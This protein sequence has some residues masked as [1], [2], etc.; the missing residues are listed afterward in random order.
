MGADDHVSVFVAFDQRQ[1][2]FFLARRRSDRQ[3]HAERFEPAPEHSVMLFRQN[4]R[5]RHERRL[6]ARLDH[7]QD[8]RDRNHRFP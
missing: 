3:L 6:I 7:E 2:A 1:K 8:R 4:L 5:R